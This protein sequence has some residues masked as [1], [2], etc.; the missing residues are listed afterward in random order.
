MRKIYS[1]IERA[2]DWK[3]GNNTSPA[4]PLICCGTPWWLFSYSCSSPLSLELPNFSW[5]HSCPEQI[6]YFSDFPTAKFGHE[7]EFWPKGWRWNGNVLREKGD[8][9]IHWNAGA[10]IL[11]HSIEATSWAWQRNAAGDWV[12]AYHFLDL[13][14]SSV[15]EKWTLS[16]F[17]AITVFC[18][19]TWT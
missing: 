5:V 2:F 6:L 7:T 3:S 4:M 9:L 13:L 16:H 10:A 18:H 17:T 11:D 19:F 8:N 14:L 12:L 1:V 15:K